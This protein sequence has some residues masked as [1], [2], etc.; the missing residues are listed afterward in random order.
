VSPGAG[1]GQCLIR[2]VD[3]LKHISVGAGS[4]AAQTIFNEGRGMGAPV[5]WRRTRWAPNMYLMWHHISD[6][7]RL[8]L[9]LNNPLPSPPPTVGCP[10][11]PATTTSL[12]HALRSYASES[13]QLPTCVVMSWRWRMASSG[14]CRRCRRGPHPVRSR[15]MV[16]GAARREEVVT[17][18][19][20][21]GGGDIA[22]VHLTAHVDA[23][24]MEAF[25]PRPDGNGTSPMAGNGM[26]ASFPRVVSQ[27]CSLPAASSCFRL[28]FFLAGIH[29]LLCC[30]AL[31]LLSRR[32][33]KVLAY[34]Q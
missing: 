9:D 34:F 8:F 4:D 23:M 1:C 7:S 26:S 14:E 32:G 33:R 13:T 3:L 19:E 24:V 16:V 31:C 30:T 10:M 18:L 2:C 12:R 6:P 11:A 28:L 27:H 25:Q 5:R 29:L 21:G 22:E 15:R 20:D 17:T